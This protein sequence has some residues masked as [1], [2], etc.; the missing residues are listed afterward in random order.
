MARR[1]TTRAAQGSGTIR[2]RKNG[3]W[4]ARYTVGRDPGTGKQV[5]RS[6]Y[7]DTQAEVRKKLQEVCVA[8]DD[9]KYMEPSKMT[10]AMWLDTW[11][12]EY[13]G[14]LK[15]HSPATYETRC[16][17]HIKPALGAVT[18][19]ALSVTDIQAFCN[20]LRKQDKAPKTIKSI[21]GILHKA[22]SR[23]QWVH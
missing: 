17:V 10:L 22:L 11:L 5:R 16:R 4:E 23:N 9:G 20:K 12:E 2:Q 6:I 7:G 15:G 14:N 19:S 8:I 13:C 18:L 3:R 21:I 1:K